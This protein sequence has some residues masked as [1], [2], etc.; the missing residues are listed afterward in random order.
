VNGFWDRAANDP[1]TGEICDGDTRYVLFRSDVIAALIGG[2][3]ETARTQALIAF[4]D[5]VHTNGGLSLQRYF[6]MVDGDVDA[7]FDTVCRTAGELGWGAWRIDRSIDSVVLDV[8]N[9]PFAIIRSVADEPVCAPILGMFRALAET[10][11]D[12]AP[13]TIA[14]TGCVALGDSVCTFRA[15]CRQA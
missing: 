14:E 13:D 11:F 3:D 2:L 12:D 1:R 5:A 15:E 7:L 6:R 8:Q 10:V 4:A 9:S